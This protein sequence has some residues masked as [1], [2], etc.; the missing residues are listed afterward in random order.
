PA[1]DSELAGE[2]G[3]VIRLVTAHY[4]QR[5]PIDTIV[6]T[7]AALK[8][9]S[10]SIAVAVLDGLMSGWPADKSPLLSDADK[11]TLPQVMESLPES[12]RDRLLALAQRWGQPNLFGASVA[13]IIE[14]LKTQITDSSVAEEK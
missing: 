10:P 12:A 5:G 4:A 13:A 6:P 14:S 7:L 11:Q 1:G 9:A 3:R 8:G 2:V